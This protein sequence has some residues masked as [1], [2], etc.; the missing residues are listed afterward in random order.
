[1]RRD[2]SAAILTAR[3]AKQLHEEMRTD[4][5]R[6]ATLSDLAKDLGRWAERSE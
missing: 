5:E 4:D 1:L 2:V 6:D 3:H